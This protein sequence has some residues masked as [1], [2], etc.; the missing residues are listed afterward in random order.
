MKDTYKTQMSWSLHLLEQAFDQ[1]QREEE[2][3]Q[4][5]EPTNM[6]FITRRSFQEVLKRPDVQRIFDNMDIEAADRSDLFD[7]I[8]A[9]SNGRIVLDELVNGLVRMSG[10]ARRADAV[11]SRLKVD[12]LMKRFAVAHTQVLDDHRLILERLDSLCPELP[13][14]ARSTS[15]ASLHRRASKPRRRSDHTANHEVLA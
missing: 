12:A 4:G 14:M 2:S 10:K 6:L 8:D 5:I 1:A 3:K 15:N 9:D 13:V 7:A 11:A